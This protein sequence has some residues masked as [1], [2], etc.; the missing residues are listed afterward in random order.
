LT[1]KLAGQPLIV[2]IDRWGYTPL[3]PTPMT[4]QSLAA[5]TGAHLAGRSPSH[6]IRTRPRPVED[7]ATRTPAQTDPPAPTL[8]DGRSYLRGIQAR[9]RAHA[10]L[11]ALD[12]ILDSVATRADQLLDELAVVVD[13]AHMPSDTGE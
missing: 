5:I 10:D 12:D 4:E 6:R 8:L 1:E 2:S 11:G 9:R 13:E 7:A 3:V